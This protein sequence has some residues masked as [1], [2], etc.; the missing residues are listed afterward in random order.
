MTRGWGIWTAFRTQGRGIWP[1]KIKNSNARGC[2]YIVF[3]MSKQSM[4]YSAGHA[5]FE[6]IRKK[7]KK[8]RKKER[9]ITIG[10]NARYVLGCLACVISWVPP[11][12]EYYCTWIFRRSTYS[13][14]SESELIWIILMDFIFTYLTTSF[15]EQ[16]SF[17]RTKRAICIRLKQF[18]EP[19]LKRLKSILRSWLLLVK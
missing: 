10:E 4:S 14:K 18:Q 6:Q 1:P 5:P 17:G 8:G 3:I 15:F 13:N 7:K 2:I 16:N 11:S 9:K 12:C 19:W